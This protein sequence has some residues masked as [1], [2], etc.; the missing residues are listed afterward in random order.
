MKKKILCII[1]LVIAIMGCASKPK[2]V[3]AAPDVLPVTDSPAAVS[4][5]K[6][7]DTAIEEAAARIDAAFNTGTEIALISILSP[8]AQFSAYVLS[9]LETVLVNNGKLAVVDRANLDK[10]RAEQGFQLSGDVSDESAKA[11]GQLLGAG[12]IVTG[13]LVDLGDAQRL[14]IKSINVQTAKIAASYAGDID[15]SMRVKT[16]LAAKGGA[17]P[18]GAYPV[19]SNIRPAAPVAAVPTT[20]A[21]SGGTSER[22]AAPIPAAVP[23]P[24]PPPAPVSYKVGDRGPAG[25]W[26]FYDMGFTM[27]GWRYLEAAPADIP[28][29]WQCDVQSRKVSGTS[30]GIGD[31]KRNTQII[32]EFLNQAGVTMKAAQVADAYEYG[33]FGDWF[34]PSRD[35]LDLMYKNLKAKGLGGFQSGSYW[36]SSQ[37]DSWSGFTALQKFS[38]GSQDTTYGSTSYLVRAIRQF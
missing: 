12:A 11:I 10:I 34:L 30:K 24:A 13:S 38:D 18:G 33:V 4:T 26:V 31:G 28:G 23:T 21:A 36:T 17:V 29:I 5:G 3:A 1:A 25:G 9:Y 6:A 37:T 35:E 8:S 2:P 27:N 32:V 7:L 16:L 22:A 20:P 14:N 19:A 15:N